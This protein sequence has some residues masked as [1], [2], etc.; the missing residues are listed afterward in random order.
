[1]R[2]NSIFVIGAAAPA[3]AKKLFDVP[4]GAV[5]KVSIIDSTVRFGPGTPDFL[6]VTPK[7]EGFDEVPTLPSLSFLI[8]SPTGKKA[9]FDLAVPKDALNSSAPAVLEALAASG[10]AFSVEKNVADILKD[11]GVDPTSI[12]SII[13]SHYHYDHTGDINTFPKATELVVGPGFS[14]AYLPGYPTNPNSTL[15][16]KWFEDRTVREIPFTTSLKAGPF[17]AYDFFS[18][19]SFYLLDTPGHTVGHLAGLARTSANPDT[20]IFMGGD[21]CHYSGHIRPSPY[22]PIPPNIKVPLPG[23]DSH[24]HSHPHGPAIPCPG[25]VTAKEFEYL[26]IK[27]NRK[28]DAPFFDPVL[29]EDL[30]LMK[31]TIVKAE[32]ADGDSDVWFVVAH[33]PKILEVAEVFPKS[34]NAWKKKGWGEKAHWKFLRDLVPAV[35]VDRET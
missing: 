13:W 18:D 22:K 32:T 9:V 12:N 25:A 28:P 5:A 6:F 21:L 11:G 35:K 10:F 1:M 7:L 8:E 16:D 14:K 29:G 23:S 24:S 20:F 26:N 30:P 17:R 15:L 19:G 3:L 27:R 2:L 4:H 33:D 34:A 31:E